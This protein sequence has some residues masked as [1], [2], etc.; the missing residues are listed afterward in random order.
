[1]RCRCLAVLACAAAL[2]A[3]GV[4][5][6]A[7]PPAGETRASLLALKA[8]QW[9]ATPAL[10]AA[11]HQTLALA[12]VDCLADPDP[13]LRDEIAFDAL[14]TW[15][16]GG[17]LTPA[18]L[19]TLRSGLLATLAAPADAAGFRQPFAALVLAEVARVDRLQ[20]FL[21]AD[22]RNTLVT[23]A[24]RYLAGV[25]D[26]RGFDA[27]EGWRHGV[28]HGADLL[29]QL[30]LNPALQRTQAD[31]LLD[32]IAA[33]VL[34]EAAQPWHHGEPGRLAAPVFFLA[35]RDL[36]TPDDWQRWFDALAARVPRGAPTTPAL[37]AQRH[38]LGAFLS[39]LYV[40]VQESPDAG[41]KTRLLP[42]LR[43]ALRALG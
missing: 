20:P 28:A 40:G 3:A 5:Q 2:G 7:C 30:A 38:N 43:R 32:A 35:R 27:T 37:L 17:L 41:V 6:A 31:T 22:E 39:G 24:A 16:R 21:T 14:Q 8:G 34:P 4:A 29:L 18:T 23:Q 26:L 12:L 36:L 33:Q 11:A 13:V 10:P 1:M 19:H 42:A 9:Q 25:R 15:M